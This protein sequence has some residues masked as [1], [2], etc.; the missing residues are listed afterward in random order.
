MSV[1]QK[2]QAD[3]SDFQLV[4]DTPKQAT[5]V[6]SEQPEKKSEQSDKKPKVQLPV[7]EQDKDNYFSCVLSNKPYV[8]VLE[9]CNGKMRVGLRTRTVKESE[10]VLQRLSKEVSGKNIELMADYQ[11]KYL[12]HHLGYALVSI[13]DKPYDSGSLDGRLATLQSMNNQIYMILLELLARFD[14]K[15]NRLREEA[16][17]VN[18]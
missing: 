8:E 9:A 16:L 12:M 7:T 13:N 10:D 17:K 5:P 18:F 6:K 4:D 15:M 11:N 1:I 3:M 14:E 2:E